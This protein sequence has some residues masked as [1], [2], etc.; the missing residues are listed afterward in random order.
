[1]TDASPA[2]GDRE[3]TGS[4]RLGAL[5]V[6]PASGVVE[7]PG[8]SEQVD[9]RVMAVLEALARTPRELVSRTSL[10][11]GIW[12]GGAIYDDTLTQCV[13]QLRQHLA[14][15]GG[16]DEYR[17]LVRTLPKRG[18]LLDC[19]VQRLHSGP[20]RPATASAQPGRTRRPA[21]TALTVLLVLVGFAGW[22]ASREPAPAPAADPPVQSLPADAIAVLPFLNAGGNPAD[23]YLSEGIADDLR[24]RI[25]AV[26]EFS[27]VARRSSI[28]FRDAAVDTREIGRQLGVGRIIE[29]RF[30][31][32]GDRITVTV[33][34]V[35]ALTGFQLWS[36]RYDPDGRDLLQLENDLFNDVL[37]QLS[38]D[39]AIE[40][41][42]GPATA[43][44]LAAH[45]LILLG[46]QYERQITD[47]Q[48]VD[49]S[50]V[51]RTVELYAEAVQTDPASAE[52]H[53][54][55]GRMLLYQGRVAEAERH[56]REALRLDPERSDAFSALG[57]LLWT[58]RKD[59]IGAAYRRAIELNPS[60]ADA[61]S[62][63][64]SWAW[65]QGQGKEA[66]EHYRIALSLDPLSLVRYADLGYKLAFQGF[67]EEALEILERLT[68][69]HPT[70]PGY[71]AAARITEALGDIDEAIAW[72][73]KA[74]Q[75][76]PEDDDIAGQVAELLARVGAFE[77]ASWF[78][79]EPGMGQLFWQRRYAELVELG[80]DLAIEAP[81]DT[82]LA[83][84]LAFGYSAIGEHGMAVALYEQV[85]LPGNVL[86][87][88]RRAGDLQ[89]SHFYL[90]D[91]QRVGRDV[92]ATRLADWFNEFDVGLLASD[93]IGG[94]LPHLTHACD[95]A[96][97]GDVAGAMA[98]L[99]TMAQ[100][101]T[102][103]RLPWLLDGSC[104][105]GLRSEPRFRAVVESVE[106]RS[107]QLRMRIPETLAR[108]GLRVDSGQADDPAESMPPQRSGWD[109]H[110]D[111]TNGRNTGTSGWSACA[112]STA[113]SS[114]GWIAP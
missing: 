46:R 47:Q 50:Q 34:L 19:D 76:R 9:P 37:G 96:V 75:Q 65:M 92:E 30:D 54:R 70:V 97:A 114:R 60:D 80:E 51:A 89:W 68:E 93:G 7:G 14:A 111:S 35:D 90:G 22:W 55:L 17:H 101:R 59:G 23:D 103:P 63:Y 24:D 79:P 15:A 82:D 62:Y 105:A 72:A 13:Y 26:S 104:F 71:L 49:V 39:L 81:D 61:H 67:R 86:S 1:M 45:D 100:L 113:I 21:V 33:E 66:V 18:Y 64:A 77:E 69:L 44:A 36:Q 31:R 10:L 95:R 52:A 42:A 74:Q 83:Y 48:L 106:E 94:W 3:P 109:R 112:S 53:A 38:P 8:G 11:E 25:A 87:E 32:I 58:Q 16:A 28:Q 99:E 6:D 98:S 88:S 56:I 110:I 4:F 108:H 85:G 102:L 78:E 2:S 73:I 107:V 29:G 57:L 91:L 40:A 43:Q 84:L 5:R 27:V 41:P 20:E 12:P